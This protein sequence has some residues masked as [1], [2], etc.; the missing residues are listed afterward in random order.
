RP[1]PLVHRFF[2]RPHHPFHSVEPAPAIGKGAD[3]WQ[4][5]TVCAR[6]HGRIARHY[7]GLVDASLVRGAFERLRGRVQVT[8]TVIDDGNTHRFTPGS[9]KRPIT[10]GACGM[11]GVGAA[12]VPGAVGAAA[13]DAL[14]WEAA[15]RTQTSK[16][17]C[18]ASSRSSPLTMPIVFQPRRLSVKRRNVPASSPTRNEIRRPTRPTMN[19]DAP[20]ALTSVSIP[21]ETT[22]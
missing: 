19:A 1:A 18:S 16:K 12:G 22:T 17:R 5:D 8:G 3:P 20:D 13:D 10:S 7:D 6:H 2:K 15:C 11:R 14:D 4:H 9:G 21:A